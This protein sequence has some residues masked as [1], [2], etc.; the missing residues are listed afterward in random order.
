M[1]KRNWPTWEPS[2]SIVLRR[3]IQIRRGGKICLPTSAERVSSGQCYP[4]I[5]VKPS[6]HLSPKVSLCMLN[7]FSMPDFHPMKSV[8]CRQPFLR[9]WWK[10]KANRNEQSC[11]RLRRIWRSRLPYRE[12]VQNSGYCRRLRFRY[13]PRYAPT[14]RNHSPARKRS[15]NK[16]CRFQQGTRRFGRNFVFN[17]YVH[18][19]EGSGG[20]N[21]SFF[22]DTPHIR[23]SEFR[24]TRS[25]AGNRTRDRF[26]W[27]RIR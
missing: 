3:R 24:V 12:R 17:G 14:G 9:G 8:I 1:S 2:S 23:G 5:S 4:P 26:Q 10:D 18:S 19:R 27:R 7:D 22:K 11:P 20:T 15:R 16:S 13:Q 6:I 21:S 25:Q